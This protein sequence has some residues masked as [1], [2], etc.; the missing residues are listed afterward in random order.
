MGGV[1][2][3]SV[4]VWVLFRQA[5]RQEKRRCITHL[6]LY[7]EMFLVEVEGHFNIHFHRYGPSVFL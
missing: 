3:V 7:F 5:I 6:P 1:D 2:P 4:V